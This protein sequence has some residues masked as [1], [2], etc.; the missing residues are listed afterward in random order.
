MMTG[1]ADLPARRPLGRSGLS[2]RPLALGGNVFGWTVDEDGSHAVLD[3]F[4][5]AGFSLVDTADVYSKWVPGHAGGESETVIGNWLKRRGGRERILIATKVGGEIR[6]GKQGLSAAHI[7]D[8]VDASLQRLQTD[9]IDLYQAHY[10]DQA[11]GFDETL[12]EFA[13]LIEEGKIRA[14]GLSNHS[15]ARMQAAIE[16]SR[17]YGLPRYETLQPLYNLHDR[18]EFEAG[19]AAI[20][21]EQ[22]IGVIS[23]KALANGF[24]SGKYRSEEDLRSSSRPGA[25]RKYM[26]ARGFRILHALDQ[27]ASDTGAR[28]AQIAI[29]WLIAQPLVTAPIAG[30]NSVEQIDELIAAARLQLDANALALLDAASADDGAAA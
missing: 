5:D 30:A 16:A 29:A 1:S 11:V 19:F 17:Q 8:A 23:F 26:D 25:N 15:P 22:S 3:R 6:P 10:D 12:G 9:Y 20:C 2:T 4:I 14:I 24:L 27:V 28:P 18:T 7:R 13:R 21:R